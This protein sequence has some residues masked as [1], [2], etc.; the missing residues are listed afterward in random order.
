M[1]YNWE[2][3]SFMP[4]PASPKATTLWHLIYLHLHYLLPSWVQPSLHLF[5][6]WYTPSLPPTPDSMHPRFPHSTSTSQTIP[7][8]FRFLHGPQHH[9]SSSEL[10]FSSSR[11]KLRITITSQN[12]FVLSPLFPSQEHRQG[13]TAVGR[14]S[15]MQQPFSTCRVLFCCSMKISWLDVLEGCLQFIRVQWLLSD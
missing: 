9:L 7:P 6:L 5:W 14:S 10:K 11:G 15:L 8:L 12:C 1:H 3:Q 4:F 2:S 13:C